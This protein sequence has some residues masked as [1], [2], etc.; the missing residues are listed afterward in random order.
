ME[1][2]TLSADLKAVS[3]MFISTHARASSIADRTSST[4]TERSTGGSP[5]GGSGGKHAPSRLLKVRDAN[6]K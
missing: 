2:R 5:L 6:D 3:S 4:E 1:S